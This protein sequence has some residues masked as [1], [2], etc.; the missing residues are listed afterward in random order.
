MSRREILPAD[1]IDDLPFDDIP[2]RLISPDALRDELVALRIAL[3]APKKPAMP[4]DI[5][6]EE[7]QDLIEDLARHLGSKPG[8]GR[9]QE[10]L[11]SATS[12]EQQAVGYQI[13]RALAAVRDARRASD[14]TSGI[15]GLLLPAEFSTRILLLLGLAQLPAAWVRRTNLLYFRP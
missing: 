11:Q 10:W 5:H 15:S 6:D 7:W 14:G 3:D 8:T 12:S 13:A 1:A 2:L 9:E 4:G